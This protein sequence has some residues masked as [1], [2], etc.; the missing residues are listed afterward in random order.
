[1]TISL[2]SDNEMGRQIQQPENTRARAVLILAA[3]HGDP[4]IDTFNPDRM[5]MN[6][7]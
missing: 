4:T 3:A 6:T 5:A 2:V 7:L 1:M